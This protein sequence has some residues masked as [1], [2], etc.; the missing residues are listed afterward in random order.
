MQDVIRMVN[1]KPLKPKIPIAIPVTFPCFSLKWD[2]RHANV[3]KV[4]V[5]MLMLGRNK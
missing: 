4:D 3:G 2:Q 1:R 5:A